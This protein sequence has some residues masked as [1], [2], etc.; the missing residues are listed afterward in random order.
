MLPEKA[1]QCGGEV[2][3]QRSVGIP[4]IAVQQLASKIS[5]GT[6]SSRPQSTWIL[7]QWAQVSH[8]RISAITTT[9]ARAAASSHVCNDNPESPSSLTSLHSSAA[10]RLSCIMLDS[11]FHML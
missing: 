1:E 7:P 8:A 2:G 3:F 9:V 4:E 6:Y 11:V 10:Y 5:A